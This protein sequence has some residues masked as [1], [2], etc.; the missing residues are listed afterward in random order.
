MEPWNVTI[1][2][3]MVVVWARVRT[4]VLKETSSLTRTAVELVGVL[5]FH[6]AN[7]AFREPTLIVAEMVY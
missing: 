1:P 3:V 2:P 6:V 7:E 4:R 5:E